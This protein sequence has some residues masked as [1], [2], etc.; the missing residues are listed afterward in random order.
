ME[1]CLVI[2]ILIILLAFLYQPTPEERAKLERL[3]QERQ[4]R[5]RSTEE[6]D[7]EAWIACVTA[8]DMD[9]YFDD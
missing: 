5:I 1:G 3:R 9:E 8:M 7:E 4:R 2:F 6:E